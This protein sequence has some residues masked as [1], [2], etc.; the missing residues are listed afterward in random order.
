MGGEWIKRRRS[1]VLG[2]KVWDHPIDVARSQEF[3][4]V[5]PESIQAPW[6]DICSVTVLSIDLSPTGILLATGSTD[7]RARICEPRYFPEF[8]L[9][10]ICRLYVSFRE[11][12]YRFVTAVG[13]AHNIYPAC[14]LSLFIF[15]LYA[16]FSLPCLSFSTFD[17]IHTTRI[18]FR[19]LPLLF[20]LVLK[21]LLFEAVTPFNF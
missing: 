13:S 1:S 3:G 20:V 5:V 21:V 8:P 17:V 10:L 9:A 2:R 6:A 12:Y 18:A 7:S 15:D 14:S 4:S 16:C 19:P 11:I